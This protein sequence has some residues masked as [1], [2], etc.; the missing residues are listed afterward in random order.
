MR[1]DF[2]PIGKQWQVALQSTGEAASP[3]LVVQSVQHAGRAAG[4]GTHR[5]LKDSQAF[6]TPGLSTSH[7][8]PGMYI[9]GP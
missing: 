9:Q 4:F 7:R 5:P 2:V 1:W 3:Y 8:H 6:L